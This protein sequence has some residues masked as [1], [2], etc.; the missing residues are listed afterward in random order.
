MLKALT[1]IKFDLLL[2]DICEFQSL[3][4]EVSKPCAERKRPSRL[5]TKNCDASVAVIPRLINDALPFA[6]DLNS[7]CETTAPV[8]SKVCDTNVA[9]C[10]SVP[11]TA[12]PEPLTFRP[13][14]VGRSLI[15]NPKLVRASATLRAPCTALWDIQWF[16]SGSSTIIYTPCTRTCITYFKI[17]LSVTSI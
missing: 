2:I 3:F 15:P 1:T 7:A 8:E 14:N 6:S 9:P 11:C 16:P 10:V 5:S 12:I 17:S 4:N 13:L